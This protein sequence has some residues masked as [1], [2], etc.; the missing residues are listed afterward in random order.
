MASNSVFLFDLE[1][2][3]KSIASDYYAVINQLEEDGPNYFDVQL[4]D[5]DE[6]SGQYVI[7]Q[8]VEETY[9]DPQNRTFDTRISPKASIV[10]FDIINTKLE[11]WGNRSN[12]NKFIFA[13]SVLLKSVTISSVDV[14][15]QELIN[16]LFIYKVTVGKVS[17]EDFL[18]TEDIVGNFNVDLSSYGDAYAVLNKYRDKISRMIVTL[19]CGNSSLKLSLTSKGTITVFR[20]RDQFEDDELNMLHNLFYK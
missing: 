14:S 15:L 12:C 7:V 10:Y 3:N 13:L 16:K 4:I 11:V 19:P 6:L 20:Q 1:T 8:N 2:S 5:S 9:Y 18:F 17:F